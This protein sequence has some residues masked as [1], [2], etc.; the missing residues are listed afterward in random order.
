MSFD[1]IAGFSG[2][3]SVTAD[4]Q[5]KRFETVA[6]DNAVATLVLLNQ[7][8]FF[9]FIATRSFVYETFSFVVD[10][11]KA[12]Y[13]VV[14]SDTNAFVR[15]R[16]RKALNFS[17]IDYRSPDFARR[18]SMSPVE[19][20]EQLLGRPLRRESKAATVFRFAPNPPAASMTPFLARMKTHCLSKPL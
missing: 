10:K 4:K 2:T 7:N 20:D 15:N 16:S 5:V 14:E 11:D 3:D 17:Q 19:P 12:A 1:G 13:V 6:V 18:K 8:L 9:E